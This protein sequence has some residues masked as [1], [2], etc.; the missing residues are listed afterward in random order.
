MHIYLYDSFLNQKKYNKVISKIETRITDLDLNG[1]IVRMNTTNSIYNI[2]NTEINNGSKTIVC[3]G[4]NYTLNQTINSIA[5]LS[6]K[7]PLLNIAIGF[8]PV[9]KTDNSIANYL[10][11]KYNENACNAISAR[12]IKRICLG[13]IND[14]EYFFNEATIKSQDTIVEINENY[15][16][17]TINNSVFRIINLPIKN[18]S[19]K[20]KLKNNKL[21]LFIEQKNSTLGFNKPT[22]KN[23]FYC[24]KIR[25]IN[26][27]QP[28]FVDDCVET[29]TP[30]DMKISKEIIKLIIGK[31]L[32]WDYH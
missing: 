32:N 15:T 31:N 12:R 30:A 17:E 20:T 1:K 8:I 29:K 25:I 3:V 26:K 6:I 19:N 11:I 27:N 18:I 21:K 7:N 16:L 28:I 4:N 13:I 22:H 5:K 2:V 9:G 14:K 24:D 23:L 10:G